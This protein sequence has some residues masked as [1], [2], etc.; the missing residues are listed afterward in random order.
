VLFWVITKVQFLKIMKQ[1][2]VC[3]ATLVHKI[4]DELG[5]LA[6]HA[7]S[8]DVVVRFGDVL[9][10]NNPRDTQEF[11]YSGGVECSTTVETTGDTI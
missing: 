9:L 8:V 7:M 6:A 1:F 3:A 2:F 4:K 10:A 5:I 11:V